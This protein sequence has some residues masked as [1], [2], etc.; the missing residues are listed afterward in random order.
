[1]FSDPKEFCNAIEDVCG[2]QKGGTVKVHAAKLLGSLSDNV[3]GFYQ[4]MV[5]FAIDAIQ[6]SMKEHVPTNLS[7]TANS[8][9][10]SMAD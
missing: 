3:P 1:M 4:Q 10:D 2:E 9:D 6:R 5:I 8:P 7:F